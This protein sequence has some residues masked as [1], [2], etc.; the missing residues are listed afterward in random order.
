MQFRLRLIYELPFVTTFSVKRLLRMW[1][2]TCDVD[3]KSCWC[4]CEEQISHPEAVGDLETQSNPVIMPL[5]PLTS[6]L[7]PLP[8]SSSLSLSVIPLHS[9]PNLVPLGE[10]PTSSD[11]I[12][13]FDTSSN[14][15]IFHVKTHHI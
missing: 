11:A 8:P 13:H 1:I 7:L 6:A 9:P 10:R 3:C 4:I 12:N 14:Y 15:F 5:C 2:K